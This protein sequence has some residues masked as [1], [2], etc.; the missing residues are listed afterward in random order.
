MHVLADI[1]VLDRDRGAVGVDEH[2]GVHAAGIGRAERVA[3]EIA[4][5]DDLRAMSDRELGAGAGRSRCVTPQPAAKAAAID[6]VAMMRFMDC[7][8]LRC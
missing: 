4:G 2:L 6:S 3:G 8:S 1:A 5:V 7:S